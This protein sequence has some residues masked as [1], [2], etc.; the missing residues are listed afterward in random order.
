[1][2]DVLNKLNEI[3][4]NDETTEESRVRRRTKAYPNKAQQLIETLKKADEEKETTEEPKKAG[5][6]A[7]G[8]KR[9]VFS[10][11]LETELID[12]INQLSKET[13]LTR[14][15]ITEKALNLFMEEQA[16]FYREM[17]GKK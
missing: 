5:R 4:E 3:Q 16:S 1:M 12:E 13:G 2:D 17:L 15:M 6:P 8:I 7:T 14:T 11:S 10:V 9:N